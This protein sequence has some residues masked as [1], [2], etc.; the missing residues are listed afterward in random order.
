MASS[1]AFGQV[2]GHW[3]AQVAV[4]TG[5]AFLSQTPAFGQPMGN[6]GP[7]QRTNPELPSESKTL[8]TLSASVTDSRLSRCR[9]EGEDGPRKWLFRK[10]GRRQAGPVLEGSRLTQAQHWSSGAGWR[11]C[12]AW[13]FDS[14]P[15]GPSPGPGTV[16]SPEPPTPLISSGGPLP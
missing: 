6:R 9:T 14:H 2:S 11:G 4:N 1:V 8:T 12:G 10:L 15:Q 3:L 7:R 13:L 16:N 5:K